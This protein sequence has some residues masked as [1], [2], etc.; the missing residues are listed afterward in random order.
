MSLL[1]TEQRALERLP[2]TPGLPLLD[3][4]RQALDDYSEH[5]PRSMC[6]RRISLI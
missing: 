4:D 3:L 5:A 1:I 6:R 2:E